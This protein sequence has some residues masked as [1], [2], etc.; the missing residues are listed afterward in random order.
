MRNLFPVTSLFVEKGETFNIIYGN[1]KLKPTLQNVKLNLN[2]EI[3]GNREEVL[4]I[5]IVLHVHKIALEYSLTKKTA[6]QAELYL[7]M[8]NFWMNF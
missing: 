5:L 4:I 3:K 7:K 8:L 6:I 1:E 2:D